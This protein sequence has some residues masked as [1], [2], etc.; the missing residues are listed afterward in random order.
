MRL[1]GFK[2]PVER[3][4]ATSL[5]EAAV[6]PEMFRQRRLLK[7]RDRTWLDG[8]LGSVHHSTI[9]ENFRWK[10]D[11]G[12]DQSYD[13]QQQVYMRSWQEKI[14]KDGEPEWKIHPEKAME[15]GL[16]MIQS[17]HTE[18][19]PHVNPLAV[20]EWFEEEIP[21]IPVPLVGKID[22]ETSSAINEFK[23]AKQKV[24]KPKPKWR[25]QGRIYQLIVNK[26]VAW[27]VTT[28]QVTPQNY[29][30]ANT[31]TLLMPM[32]NND[33]T[34]KLIQQTAETINDLYIRYGADTPW[35][36]NGVFGDWTCDYCPFGPKNPS[37]TCPAWRKQ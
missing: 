31:P 1:S 6:C 33:N 32:G 25:F 22:V 8:F 28:K 9:E 14:D 24:S 13:T 5:A 16:K 29:T 23:T 4:S 18:V 26:P 27:T 11:T 30:E 12:R 3:L 36:T 19:A 21:G 37:P 35:P 34:V 17:F 20:E 10:M 2:V 15:L 7:Y